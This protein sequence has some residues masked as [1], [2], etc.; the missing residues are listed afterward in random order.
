MSLLQANAFAHSFRKELSKKNNFTYE[1]LIKHPKVFDWVTCEIN[2]NVRYQMFLANDDGV[3]LR[4]FW[5]GCYEAFAMK[6]WAELSVK[7]EVIIDV[8]AHTGAYTLAAMAANPSAKI[9]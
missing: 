7:S 5:N 4:F 3:A 1:E 9:V 6:I 2:E 8:G